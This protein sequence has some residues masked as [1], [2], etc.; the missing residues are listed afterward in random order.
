MYVR[1]DK[2]AILIVAQPTVPTLMLFGLNAPV[3]NPIIQRWR[4]RKIAYPNTGEMYINV[5]LVVTPHRLC[6][7]GR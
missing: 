2:G 1:L 3:V 7:L 6:V 5:Y 4:Y